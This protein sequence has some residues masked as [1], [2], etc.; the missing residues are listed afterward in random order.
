MVTVPGKGWLEDGSGRNSARLHSPTEHYSILIG[1]RSAGLLKWS[2]LIGWRFV[3]LR[4]CSILI[5]GRSTG[6]LQ[7]SILI[8]WRLTGL[9]EC[10]ILIGWRSAGF[11]QWE[12]PRVLIGHRW[13]RVGAGGE[14]LGRLNGCHVKRK[15]TFLKKVLKITFIN[16]FILKNNIK[17]FL[18]NLGSVLLRFESVEVWNG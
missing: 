18:K 7:R 14:N 10:S 5:S 15:F 4:K 16:K 6:L 1:W 8:G 3:R 2:I 9:L 17:G 13:A 11:F 12:R